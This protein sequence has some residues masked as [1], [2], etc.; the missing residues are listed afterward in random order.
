MPPAARSAGTRTLTVALMPA[1]QTTWRICKGEE[2]RA[3]SRLAITCSSA[4]VPMRKNMWQMHRPKAVW[5]M[6][7]RQPKASCACISRQLP[8]TA[9]A[10]ATGSLKAVPPFLAPVVVCA[11]AFDSC[12]T[13]LM[14]MQLSPYSSRLRQRQPPLKTGCW[15]HEGLRWQPGERGRGRRRG[16]GGACQAGTFADAQQY[17]DVSSAREN[18]S[19]AG[20][21]RLAAPAVPAQTALVSQAHARHSRAGTFHDWP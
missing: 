21:S 12:R 11:R 10:A 7:A 20:A 3:H 2:C 9:A 14:G 13:F 19:S 8:A 1:H 15:G 4:N 16:R 5:S 18:C 17:N 6:L